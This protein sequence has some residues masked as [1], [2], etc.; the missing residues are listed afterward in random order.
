MENDMEKLRD[1]EDDIRIHGNRKI[2][3]S[4]RIE[5]SPERVYR[6]FL[7][8]EDLVK[9]YRASDGWTTPYAK[10]DER[11]GGK[12]VIRFED[13]EGKNSFDYEG[14]FTELTSPEKIA[15][16]LGDERMVE[17]LIEKDGDDAVTVTETFDA[18]PTHTEEQQRGG[19]FAIL[20]NLRKYLED[21][22]TE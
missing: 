10:V 17:I 3:V 7:D 11:I 18:E 5:A 9:W 2:K 14:E 6:A 16:K 15:Y 20:V 22:V 1:M 12:L 13:P 4:E 19:W 21:G 8:E